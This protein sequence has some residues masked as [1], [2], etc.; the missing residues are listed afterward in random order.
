MNGMSFGIPPGMMGGGPGF[1]PLAIPATYGPPAAPPPVYTGTDPTIFATDYPALIPP[2]APPPA[3]P[4]VWYPPMALPDEFIGPPAPIS[5]PPMIYNWEAPLDFS[6]LTS[7]SVGPSYTQEPITEGLVFPFITPAALPLSES[8][9][10]RTEGPV[11]F[12]PQAP[13]DLSGLNFGV[14]TVPGIIESQDIRTG[15]LESIWGFVGDVVKGAGDVLKFVVDHLDVSVGYMGDFGGVKTQRDP[16][17]GGAPSPVIL[18]MP[19]GAG[20]SVRT[21]VS[22]GAGGGGGPPMTEEE[23]L[24]REAL[25]VTEGDSDKFIAYAGLA[26]L[27]YELLIK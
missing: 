18:G 6:W 5:S 19:G 15:P 26:L 4:P 11:W 13:L 10:I 2:A 23:R 17:T 22:T 9:A 24:Y 25:Q 20:P 27:T 21:T 7:P 14:A 8:P 1:S 3:A 16:T 12:D